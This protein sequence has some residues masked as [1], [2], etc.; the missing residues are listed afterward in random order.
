MVLDLVSHY[1]VALI[2]AALTLVVAASILGQ[3]RPT[4][5]A[6]A[7]LLAVVLIPYL[8]IP[9]YLMI[10]GRKVRRASRRK[11]VL[12]PAAA[13][14]IAIAGAEAAPP[15]VLEWL[16]DGVIAYEAFVREIRRAR[17]GIRIET[18]LIG[19][20]EVGEA[21]LG[22]LA[23]KAKEGVAIHL[24]IDAFLA[25]STP[26]V[27]L[28]RLVD[29]GGRVA[30]FMPLF[31][32]PF[33]GR[34]NLRNHR[35]IAIFDG[36]RAIVG[37]MNLAV[38][39]MGPAPRA[40]RWRDLSV[41]VD[42]GAVSAI[43][44][45]FRADWEFAAHESLAAAG[46]GV[47]LGADISVIPS[48]PDGP[49]DA[50]YDLIL[51]AVY[52]AERRLWVATPYYVPDDALSRALEISTRRGVD[53]R[54]V[55]PFRSNHR[56]ADLVGGPLLRELEAAGGRV[57]RYTPSMLHGKV[58][59]ADD[60]FALVG[61]ANFDM[62]SMFLNYEVALSFTGAAEV[63]RVAAWFE[64]TLAHTVVGVPHP[65]W[66]RAHVEDTCRLIAPLV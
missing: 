28:R 14:S 23:V 39:Y 63:A 29:A 51:T 7:W 65:R 20:D 4:G 5:T 16:D 3:R 45:V 53:V 62:R 2:I 35:K 1:V 43:D 61:S 54:V 40:E 19:R 18:Y 33:R 48:G 11:K 26:R 17:R 64:D 44:A 37:G 57:H 59:L 6:F 58:V 47:G 10:G 42:G 60:R 9:L 27:P 55:V 34:T 46:T 12:D 52:R 15:T 25:S 36:D 22:E 8:G 32:L 49:Q 30:R 50:I 24:L 21:I 56:I 41:V 31:H 66:L 38:D 13:P